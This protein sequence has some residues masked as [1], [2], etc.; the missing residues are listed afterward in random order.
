MFII[1]ASTLIMVTFKGRER[2]IGN[3]IKKTEK[4][5]K[6]N[7]ANLEK[8]I[9][10]Y[11]RSSILLFFYELYSYMYSIKKYI[12]YIHVNQRGII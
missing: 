1:C 5:G 7:Y 8:N 3:R 10:T 4:K 2:L 6:E 11:N 12:N 9:Q